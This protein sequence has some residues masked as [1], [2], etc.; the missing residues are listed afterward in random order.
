MRSNSTLII[1]PTLVRSQSGEPIRGL[2]ANR[3][4]LT[5][6]GKEQNIYLEEVENQPLAMVVLIQ[7]GGAA[8]SELGN[9]NKLDSVM[10][11]VLGASPSKLAFVSFDSHVREIWAFP[12]RIDGLDYAMTHQEPG[13]SGAAVLDAIHCG[14]NLLQNQPAQYRRI[15]LLLSQ[16]QDS[17]SE[18]NSTDVL[19]DVARSGTTIYSFTFLSDAIR[20]Q[21][22][23]VRPWHRRSDHTRIAPSTDPT[24]VDV[25]AESGGESLRF[26]GENDLDQ[27]LLAVGGDIR[28]GYILSFRPSS[29]SL[30]LHTVRVQVMEQAE[31]F[32]VLARKIY[33][34]D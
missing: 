8:S 13:D 5:D 34:L 28:N 11:S 9:Y 15:I 18:S 30:G 24:T 10:A 25:A 17:G 26:I 2:D 16:E 22:T 7:T 27:K 32:E 3:F 12:P 31:H 21:S 20:R 4:R 6:N 19:R 14:I 33:W 1:V 29:T 23:K